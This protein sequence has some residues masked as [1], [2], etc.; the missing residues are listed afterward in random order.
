MALSWKKLGA[1]KKRMILRSL[2]VLAAYEALWVGVFLW[3]HRAKPEGM[4][5]FLIAMLPALTVVAFIGVIAKYLGEEVDEFHRQLVVRCL[6]WGTAAV[7]TSV[8]FHGVLQ[9]LGWKGQWPAGIE[10]GLFV[11]AMGAAK[12]TYRVRHRVPD[13]VDALVG[14]GD[15]R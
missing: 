5:L 2:V 1:A 9:L 3:V 15:M 6:L 4:M 12:L 7:M 10:L 11:V 13:D 8:C 14:Q